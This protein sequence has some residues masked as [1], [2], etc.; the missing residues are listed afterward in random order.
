M[1]NTA[2]NTMMNFSGVDDLST[3]D[4][5]ADLDLQWLLAR[6]CELQKSNELLTL[7]L[8]RLRWIERSLDAEESC[9][10]EAYRSGFLGVLLARFDGSLIYANDAFLEMIGYSREYFAQ[11]KITWNDVFTSDDAL[12]ACKH[13]GSYVSR[14]LGLTGQDG[15]LTT[16]TFMARRMITEPAQMIGFAIKAKN[17]HAEAKF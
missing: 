16:L 13:V 2:R 4:I 11:K 5:Q 8:A 12:G 14:E 9:F 17:D 7:E 10:S 3:F 6:N 15:A 1:S